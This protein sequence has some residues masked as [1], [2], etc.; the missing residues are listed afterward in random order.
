[1][2]QPVTS[3]RSIASATGARLCFPRT[4]VTSLR[5]PATD[6]D[7]D[8]LGRGLRRLAL[9][10]N[11]CWGNHGQSAAVRANVQKVSRRAPELGS[12]VLWRS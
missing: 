8:A 6:A 7:V 4:V 12:F 1:L 9:H 3:R 2:L 10:E 5:R 11:D